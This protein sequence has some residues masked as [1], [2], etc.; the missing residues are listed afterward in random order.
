MLTS[1]N[2]KRKFWS[3]QNSGEGREKG[4]RQTWKEWNTQRE[5]ETDKRR[6]ERDKDSTE[7][8]IERRNTHRDAAVTIDAKQPRYFLGGRTIFTNVLISQ[9]MNET[10]LHL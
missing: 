8:E 10:I 6:K 7:R 2:Y 5:R 1:E 3:G 9:E 4:E